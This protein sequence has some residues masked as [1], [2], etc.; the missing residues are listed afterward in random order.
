MYGSMLNYVTLRI[1]GEISDGGNRTMEN[2]AAWITM[3]PQ[4]Y[5]P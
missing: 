5:L 4:Q 1:L 3:V 2:G